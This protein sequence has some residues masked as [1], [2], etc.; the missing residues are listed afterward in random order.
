MGT[1]AHCAT[2]VFTTVI[3]K[4]TNERVITDVGAKGFTMQTCSEGICKTI[5]LGYL[6]VMTRFI[7]A[8]YMMNI[9]LYIM[10]NLGIKYQS[11][12]R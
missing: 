3:S 8:R 6:K 9:R 5:G 10:K 4:P 2:T 7:L 1:Y 11:E 12:I